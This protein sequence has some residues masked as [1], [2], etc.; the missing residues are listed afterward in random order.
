MKTQVSMWGECGDA[1]EPA[2]IHDSLFEQFRASASV[3][4]DC[5]ARSAWE[6]VTDIERIGEFSPECIKATWIDG[7][8]GPLMGAR[9]EGT[10]RVVDEEDDTE[11]IWVRPCTVTVV[12]APQRFGYTVGDR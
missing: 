11:Y 5:S 8:S 7:S 4:V 12:E 1:P 2:S 9:F 3:D 10:N 6:L